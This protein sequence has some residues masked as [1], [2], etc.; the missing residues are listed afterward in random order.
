MALDTNQRNHNLDEGFDI[1]GAAIA[2]RMLNENAGFVVNALLNIALRG[3]S[4][5]NQLKA[6][7]YVLD[8]VLGRI[9]TTT[10]LNPADD[11]LNTLIKRL[12]L[13]AAAN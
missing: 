11:P 3:R 9:P 13:P 7:F 8:R 12:Q 6:C 4:E 2:K 5:S 1:D 10:E